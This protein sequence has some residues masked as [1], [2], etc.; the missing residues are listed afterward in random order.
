MKRAFRESCHASTPGE[1]AFR[2]VLVQNHYNPK[3]SVIALLSSSTL[4]QAKPGV[5]LAVFVVKLRPLLS[6]LCDFGVALEDSS[7][8][9]L[10]DGCEGVTTLTF[11]RGLDV[12]QTTETVAK[13]TYNIKNRTC[14]A[15]SCCLFCA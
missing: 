1:I 13:N 11:K 8:V 6:E 7:S 15:T 2:K 5:T 12:T 4:V 14:D 9:S 3:P 10:S